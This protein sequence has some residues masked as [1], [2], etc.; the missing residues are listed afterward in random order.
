MWIRLKAG[1]V[2]LEAELNGSKTAR[3]LWDRLPMQGEAELY[4]DEVYFYL[5]A[6]TGPEEG[7]TAAVV[8]VGAVAYS[9]QGP[10]LCFFFGP[11]PAS[12]EAECRPAS[13]VTVIGKIIGDPQRLRGVRLGDKIE[14]T[15]A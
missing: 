8:D 3:F 2:T 12:R 14:V 11:T 15:R 10:C 1:E 6:C 5:A 9:P 7:F 4:G 13:T